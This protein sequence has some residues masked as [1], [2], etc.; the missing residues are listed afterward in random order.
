M[1]KNKDKTDRLHQQMPRFYKTRT[2]PNWK[3]L[4]GALGESDED[5]YMKS[6]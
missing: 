3:A 5:L 2:N 1:A 6:V 4:I